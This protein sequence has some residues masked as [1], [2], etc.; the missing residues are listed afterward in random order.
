MDAIEL[1]H[2]RA[3]LC[4]SA[5]FARATLGGGSASLDRLVRSSGTGA[6]GRA[7]LRG[8]AL[9][10]ARKALDIHERGRGAARL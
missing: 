6:V 1:E 2:G 10:Q 3:K 9:A 7:P 8:K 4:S 5:G